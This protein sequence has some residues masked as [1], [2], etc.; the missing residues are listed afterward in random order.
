MRRPLFAFFPLL[1]LGCPST[2]VAQHAALYPM[3]GAPPARRL[4]VVTRDERHAITV[5]SGVAF[6]VVV[7]DSCGGE[8]T[9][10]L[11]IADPNVLGEHRLARNGGKREYVLVALRAGKTTVTIKAACTSQ[12][13][14]VTV[15]PQ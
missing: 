11:E 15:V 14:D 10:T 6:G 4:E 1:L 13:Y 12:S 8:S 2:P 9:P 3:T 5:S 7:S